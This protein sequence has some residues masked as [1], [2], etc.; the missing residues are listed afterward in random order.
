MNRRAISISYKRVLYK[1]TRSLRHV[2]IYLM[3]SERTKFVDNAIGEAYTS[4]DNAYAQDYLGVDAVN[5]LRT[6][7][8]R[9]VVANIRYGVVSSPRESGDIIPFVALRRGESF[10]L[11]DEFERPTPRQLDRYRRLFTSWEPSKMSVDAL[12]AQLSGEYNA[13]MDVSAPGPRVAAVART[14]ARLLDMQTLQSQAGLERAPQAVMG[15][16][17]LKPFITLRMG[18][19][20]ADL[21]CHELTHIEQKTEQPYRGYSSQ[22]N[23]DMDALGDELRAYHVGAGIRLG[24]NIAADDIADPYRQ[25]VVENVRATHNASYLD[26]FAPSV[27]L[28]D[29]YRSQGMGHILGDVLNFDHVMNAFDDLRPRAS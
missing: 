27:S 6:T 28:F 17:M 7:L 24:L 26:P 5:S 11:G 1:L 13:P 25:L 23:I 20:A 15:K 22:R 3:S 10:Q 14:N 18:N 19:A 4:L 12:T 9:A 29:T 16:F 21:L 2:K 8:D